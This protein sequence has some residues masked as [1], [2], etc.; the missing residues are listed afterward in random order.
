MQSKDR[1][2]FKLAEY[3]FKQSQIRNL[4]YSAFGIKGE[5][6]DATNNTAREQ[7]YV[8]IVCRP[9]QFARF[10]IQREQAGFQNMFKELE[11]KLFTPVPKAVIMDVST[12]PASPLL[13][14]IPGRGHHAT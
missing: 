2:K 10:L 14:A 7:G 8:E 13:T 9:S 5:V 12:N 11:A 1:V 3:Y 6:F 4:L